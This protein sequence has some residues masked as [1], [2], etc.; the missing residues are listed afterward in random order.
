MLTAAEKRDLAEGFAELAASLG[1]RSPLDDPWSVEIV[2]VGSVPMAMHPDAPPEVADLLVEALLERGDATV[3]GVLKAMERLA[4]PPLRDRARQA[5]AELASRGVISP[6]EDEIGGARLREAAIFRVDG[7]DVAI[8]CLLERPSGAG[9]A[10]GALV[11]LEPE[12]RALI[13]IRTT[14]PEPLAEAQ[15]RF[16]VNPIGG[17]RRKARASEVLEL[18][19]ASL[20]V[21]APLLD[22][23]LFDLA[24]LE[25]ALTGE[26]MRLPRPP[27]FPVDDPE[28]ENA[29]GMAGRLV[30]QMVAEGVDP[31]DPEALSAWLADFNSRPYEERAAITGGASRPPRAA[32][33]K[34]QQRRQAKS[35]RKRNRRR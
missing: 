26:D 11:Y 2:A 18:L 6:L 35:A 12:T 15:R 4:H 33:A 20:S 30:D 10:Q 21:G 22:E 3:A 5:A 16:K 29:E 8:V 9:L 25:R 31:A 27:V 28:G 17:R 24:I 19:E 23:M 1:Q 32:R 14:D 7:D 13:E 34:K